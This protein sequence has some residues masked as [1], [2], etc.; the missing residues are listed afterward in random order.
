[1]DSVGDFVSH[2]IFETIT[3]P[4]GVEWYVS[5]NQPSIGAEIGDVCETTN[6]VYT[7]FYVSGYLYEIQPEYSNRYHACVTVP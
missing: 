2:E 3:D 6:L 7:P 4:D 1:M 5:S